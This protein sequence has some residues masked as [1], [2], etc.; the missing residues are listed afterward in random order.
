MYNKI[1]LMGR[2]VTAP[3]LNKTKAGVSVTSFGIVVE[4]RYKAKG[5]KRKTDFFNIVCWYNNADFVCKHFT[6]GSMIFVEGEM[7]SH[8][9]PD[10]KGNDVTWYEV[11]AERVS[12]T[13]ER[14]SDITVPVIPEITSDISDGG[15]F[16]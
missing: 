6:K 4:R 11:L 7:Q 16:L 14:K 9:R 8:R 3:V 1:T 2:I 5:E 12:F 13:S 10:K 15:T